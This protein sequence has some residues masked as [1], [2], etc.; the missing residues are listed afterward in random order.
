MSKLLLDATD[1]QTAHHVCTDGYQCLGSIKSLSTPPVFDLPNTGVPGKPRHLRVSAIVV[2]HNLALENR[3]RCQQHG[4]T[5]PFHR[6]I[7][8]LH[9]P[10]CN[11]KWMLT[12]RRHNLN[13][14]PP[15][16]QQNPSLHAQL[17]ARSITTANNL[18]WLQSETK[19]HV[20]SGVVAAG[21]RLFGPSHIRNFDQF[22][23]TFDQ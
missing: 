9:D 1:I 11:S 4:M 21:W 16:G 18:L 22:S 12:R 10:I 7:P 23:K 3:N 15:M 17:A 13:G 2:E 8:F 19:P 5:G 20:V 6:Y 14:W